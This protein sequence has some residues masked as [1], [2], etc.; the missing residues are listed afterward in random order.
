[1]KARKYLEMS[2]ATAT[3]TIQIN[4]EYRLEEIWELEAKTKIMY[5]E[6]MDHQYKIIDNTLSESLDVYVYIWDS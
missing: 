1:M 6:Q 3:I 2:W 5:N 4:I